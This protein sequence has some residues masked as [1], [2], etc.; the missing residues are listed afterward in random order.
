M[1]FSPRRAP[2]DPSNP[3]HTSYFSDPAWPLLSVA[4]LGKDN[5]AWR[6]LLL[7]QIEQPVTQVEQG[8]R[9]PGFEEFLGAGERLLVSSGASAPSS[10][11]VAF[12]APCLSLVTINDRRLVQ[13]LGQLP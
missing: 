5:L 10:L 2:S 3:R 6:L 11:R 9:V 4:E 7:R 1:R 13:Y 12:I 8:H